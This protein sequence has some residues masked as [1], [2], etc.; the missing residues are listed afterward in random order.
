MEETYFDLIPDELIVLIIDHTDFLSLCILDKTIPVRKVFMHACAC[1]YPTFKLYTK[2]TEINWNKLYME[3]MAVNIDKHSD[4][5]QLYGGFGTFQNTT[6][7]FEVCLRHKKE[8]FYKLLETVIPNRTNHRQ[9]VDILTMMKLELTVMLREIM[10]YQ[11][12]KN[13]YVGLAIMYVDHRGIDE[14]F[15]TNHSDLLYINMGSCNIILRLYESP[16]LR[17]MINKHD[18]KIFSEAL[19]YAGNITVYNVYLGTNE[20]VN[21]SSLYCYDDFLVD[22]NFTVVY[23]VQEIKDRD[24]Y[25]KPLTRLDIQLAISKGYRIPHNDT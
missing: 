13:G 11:L 18:A 7:L 6:E 17:R 20:N 25:I 16:T 23:R 10:L 9:I 21:K 22:S 1:V 3:L 14:N 4:V 19:K 8:Q 24:V 5:V 2:D 12:I 15:F